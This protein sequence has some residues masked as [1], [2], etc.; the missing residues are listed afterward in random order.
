MNL[1]TMMEYLIERAGKV[2]SISDNRKAYI[3][4]AE[5]DRIKVDVMDQDDIKVQN[6]CFTNQYVIDIPKDLSDNGVMNTREKAERLV[7]EI[8]DNC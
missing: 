1:V 7:R 3:G 2:V 8:I 5:P 6:F 4:E